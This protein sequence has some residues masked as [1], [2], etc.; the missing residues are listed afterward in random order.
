M[1]ISLVIL[2]YTLDKKLEELAIRCAL[3]YREQV[4]QLI[5]SE[6]GGFF[7]PELYKLSDLYILGKE[8]VGFTKNVNRGWKNAQGDFVMIVNSDTQLMRGNLSN[9]CIEGKITSPIIANQYIDR[10]AGCFWCAPKE[11]TK[12]RGYLLE[13]MKTYSSDS[14]Y[15]N[16]VADIFQKVESVKIYHKMMQTVRV[17]GVEG[18]EEQQ[19]DREIYAQLI[20]EG[21]AK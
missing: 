7:S 4:D 1:K 10:L 12:N 15:D 2:T 17:A 19:R 6:D 11:V 9:L 18:G 5:V 16:R 3:S 14:E 21:K 13:D 20:K 8:N